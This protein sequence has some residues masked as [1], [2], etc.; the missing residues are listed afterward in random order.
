MKI[1]NL[2]TL[3]IFFL[4]M[5]FIF[6]ILFKL[7]PLI[8]LVISGYLVFKSLKPPNT[9]GQ[10]YKQCARCQKRADRNALE[11]GFCGKAFE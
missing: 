4:V 7:L 1:N 10:V 2:L 11:C 3:I 9:I 5:A 6:K 8:L